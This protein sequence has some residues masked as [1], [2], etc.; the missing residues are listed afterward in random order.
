MKGNWPE[1]VIPYEELLRLSRTDI[2]SGRSW[3]GPGKGQIQATVGQATG[4]E[5][6]GPFVCIGFYRMLLECKILHLSPL[7]TED[8]KVQEDRSNGQ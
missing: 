5:V 7:V 1:V 2:K 6:T 3:K 8:I 4:C